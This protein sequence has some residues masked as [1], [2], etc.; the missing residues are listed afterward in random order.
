MALID[1]KLLL[2]EDLAVPSTATTEYSTNE[3]DFEAG[4]DAF[5]AAM[6][7]PWIGRGT[8]LYLNFVITASATSTTGTLAV[9]IVHGASSSPT[10]VLATLATGLAYT[11]LVAGYKLSYALPAHPRVLRYLRLQLVT[12]TNGIPAATYTAWIDQS[13]VA[14]V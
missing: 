8:P 12:T 7:N 11:D 2:S 6:A 9:N 3:I 5:G 1:S 4:V 13:P 10:T 14:D